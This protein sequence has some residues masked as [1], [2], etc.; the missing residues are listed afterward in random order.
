[1]ARLF[2]LT[3]ESRLW[4]KMRPNPAADDSTDE[5]DTALGVARE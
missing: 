4:T 2:G 5:I 1:M 3:I